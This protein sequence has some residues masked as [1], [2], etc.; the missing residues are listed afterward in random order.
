MA[1]TMTIRISEETQK[2]FKEFAETSGFKNQNEFTAHLLALYEGQ[3][4]SARVPRLGGAISSVSTVVNL[5][6]A[7]AHWHRTSYLSVACV[8]DFYRGGSAPRTFR[9]T[10]QPLSI[11]DCAYAH[12]L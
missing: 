4:M 10:A 5:S 6:A 2:Q 11:S 9:K 7:C 8:L 12:C 1:D 3:E